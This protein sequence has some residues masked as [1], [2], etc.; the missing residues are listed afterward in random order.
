MK[1]ILLQDL[2]KLGKEARAEENRNTRGGG[3]VSMFEN[4]DVDYLK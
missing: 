4:A 1:V 3:S 2:K